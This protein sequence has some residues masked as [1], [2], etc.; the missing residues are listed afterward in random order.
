MRTPYVFLW[1][2]KNGERHWEAVAEGQSSGLLER[3]I[4]SGVNPAT[5]MCGYSPIMFHWVFKSYHNGLSDVYF[6]N[7]N[8]EIYGTKPVKTKRKPIDIPVEKK[9]EPMKY[10]WLAPDGRFFNCNYGGHSNLADKIVG[11]I[12]YVSNPERHL[13]ELG[14]AKILSGGGYTGKQYAIGM[15]LDKKLTDEQ[16]KTLTRMGLDDAFGISYLL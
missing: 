2:D 15:D 14:W 9:P 10:G 11:D 3:L 8:E 6:S 7:V 13:E 1:E 5:V 16:L 12:Q 4:N